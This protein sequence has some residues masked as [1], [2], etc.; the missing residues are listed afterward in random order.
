MKKTL[1]LTLALLLSMITFAQIR[2][3]Y[4]SEHFDSEDFP[5][6]WTFEGEGTENWQIWQTHQAGGEPKIGR[7]HV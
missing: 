5:A 4:I 2:V 1:L 6:G 7:A 3:S